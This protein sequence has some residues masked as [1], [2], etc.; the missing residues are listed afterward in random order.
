MWVSQFDQHF[1]NDNNLSASVVYSFSPVN[2]LLDQIALGLILFITTLSGKKITIEYSKTF[3]I[4]ITSRFT[5]FPGDFDGDEKS[6]DEED[7]DDD[8]WE[9]KTC[10]ITFGSKK[11][12]DEE[13][14]SGFE[15]ASN[16][17]PIK[18]SPNKTGGTSVI[19]DASS[20]PPSLEHVICRLIS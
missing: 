9:D 19:V 11:R 6:K 2:C 16:L 14:S 7:D 20:P 4:F 10:E 15:S 5:C 3:K 8:P 12:L 13:G 1:Q 17:S 18:H